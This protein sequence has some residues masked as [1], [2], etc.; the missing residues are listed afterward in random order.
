M[1]EKGLA[2]RSMK[3]KTLEIHENTEGSGERRAGGWGWLESVDLAARPQCSVL[4]PN[5][6]RQ[7]IHDLWQIR[8]NYHIKGSVWGEEDSPLL[9][10]SIMGEGAPKGNSQS[11]GGRFSSAGEKSNTAK[12]ERRRRRIGRVLICHRPP[13]CFSN[14]RSARILCKP[15]LVLLPGRA[16]SPAAIRIRSPVLDESDRSPNRRDLSLMGFV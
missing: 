2:R 11:K 4:R 5:K 14:F 12:G 10:R 13:W 15:E 7:F 8:C 9:W 6:A 16:D 1:R 3:T